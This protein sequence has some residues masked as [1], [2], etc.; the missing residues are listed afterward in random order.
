MKRSIVSSNPKGSGDIKSQ[1][2]GGNAQNS[3][4]ISTSD[5]V[6]AVDP[7]VYGNTEVEIGTRQ[8]QRDLNAGNIQQGSTG[9]IP[10]SEVQASLQSAF[11]KAQKRFDENP[12]ERNSDRLD[13]AHDDLKNAINDGECLIR[14]C[15]PAAYVSPPRPVNP[16]PP[17]VQPSV[18][19][20]PVVLPAQAESKQE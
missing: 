5:P 9:V 7:K 15:A 8:I 10:P 12:S 14:G 20:V 16:N 11:D 18:P 4:L 3:P 1:V 13:R 6:V 17:V 2:R 19:L